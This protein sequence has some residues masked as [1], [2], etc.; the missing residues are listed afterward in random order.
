MVSKVYSL[1]YQ[2][3]E[4]YPIEIEVDI[5]R[6]LPAISLVGLL[7]TAVKESK[8]RVRAGIKNSGYQF[9][10]QRVTISLAPGNVK[11]EGTHFDLAIALGILKATSQIDCDFS[12]YFIVGELSLEGRIREVKG[13]F[14]MA[15]MAKKLG[16]KLIL[17]LPNAKEAALAK[18]LEI[19][20]V[21][22]L[23]E[24]VGFLS[25][26]IN[27]QP[28]RIDLKE[29]FSTL[30][31][32]DVDFSDVKGQVLAKKALE[33]AVAGMH[34]ILLIGPPGVGKSMLA[35][36]LPTILPDMEYEEILETTKIYS[37]AGLL[38]KDFPLVKERPFRS[39]HHT[40]SSVALVGGGTTIKPG[41]V[42]LAHNGVLFLDELPEFNR[43]AL[44]GLRQPLED[45]F[46]SISRAAKHLRFPSRFL[47]VAAMNPCPCDTE[48]QQMRMFLA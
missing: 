47:L 4:V 42:T 37:I 27:K 2:G 43:D 22:Y 31:T 25:G 5:H 7:D 3:L 33:V 15:L 24:V 14:P 23:Q 1:A 40:A 30:P 41:E 46:V 39:P 11:K 45:G 48:R 17:P 13:I 12:S 10:S 26:V 8:D 6:G 16:K 34:N 19:F 32:Y 21:S 44:E 36:R 18:D 29:I 38:N 28:F 9:P 20:P 35:K